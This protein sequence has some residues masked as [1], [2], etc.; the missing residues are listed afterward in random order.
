MGENWHRVK[1]TEFGR[2]L[3]DALDRLFHSGGEVEVAVVRWFR[4]DGKR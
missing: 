3:W 4:E 1:L 2:A